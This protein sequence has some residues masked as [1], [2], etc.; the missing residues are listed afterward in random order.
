[1]KQQI[2]QAVKSGFP[3]LGGYRDLR[4]KL[5]SELAKLEQ[6]GGDASMLVMLEQLAPAFSQTLVKPQSMR[7]DSARAELRM[8]AVSSNF[9]SLEAFKRQAEASGFEIEQ[10]AINNRDNQMIGNLII[11]SGS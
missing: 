6:G 4:R 5:N 11:R 10:G 7:F 2:D 9:E 1:M 3:S 8:Q